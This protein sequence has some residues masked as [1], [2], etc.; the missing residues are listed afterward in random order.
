MQPVCL[1]VIN[2]LGENFATLLGVATLGFTVWQIK[3]AIDA[4]QA[5]T[6]SQIAARSE[7]LQWRILKDP[8]LSEL[9]TG[10][11]NPTTLQQQEIAVGM[12]INHF[13]TM[14]DL[15]RLGGIPP[16]PWTAFKLDIKATLDRPL[17]RKRWQQLKQYH[18]SD[19]VKFV[20]DELG[21]A[22]ATDDLK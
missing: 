15:H 3:R 21:L 2:W 1:L 11:P 17:F 10:N 6:V 19:F 14:Y 9:L 7:E 20:T 16:E 12:V 18:R 5:S 13:A 8:D 22:D 4:Y